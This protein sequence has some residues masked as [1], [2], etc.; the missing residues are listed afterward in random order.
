MRSWWCICWRLPRPLTACR[1]RCTTPGGRARASAPPTTVT[2]GQG[3]P[4]VT[5]TRTATLTSASRWT[6]VLAA[7]DRCSFTHYSFLA[8]DPHRLHDRYTG[9]GGGA[10]FLQTKPNN[11]PG[12]PTHLIP[13]PKHQPGHR[14]R[15]LGIH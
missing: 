7:A 13:H 14:A 4:T 6:W 9:G 12:K 2:A 10:A 8:F 11:A 5:L 3:P 1:R 15:P